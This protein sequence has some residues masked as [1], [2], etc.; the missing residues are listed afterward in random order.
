[1][2]L[3]PCVA[4]VA[5]VRGAALRT[6]PGILVRVRCWHLHRHPS[7]WLV[8]TVGEHPMARAQ[9]SAVVAGEVV[10]GIVAFHRRPHTDFTV[11][12]LS[13]Q[14]GRIGASARQPETALTR[15]VTIAIWL[16]PA[17]LHL[18]PQTTRR[19]NTQCVANGQIVSHAKTHGPRLW[20]FEH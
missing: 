2:P 8:R 17:C 9:T 3:W 13:R 18:R 15:D 7:W 1:M 19:M 20:R 14:R 4:T 6:S 5:R 12:R 11:A 10:G 16:S